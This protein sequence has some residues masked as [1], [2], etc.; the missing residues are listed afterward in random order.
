MRDLVGHQAE[1]AAPR[2]LVAAGGVEQQRI[3]NVA[4]QPP[5]LHRAFARAGHG[6]LVELGQRVGAA[7]VA[8]VK[9]QNLA[10]D[11]HRKPRLLALAR[12][13]QDA[14]RSAVHLALQNVKASDRH[15]QQIAWHR[16]RWRKAVDGG[17]AVSSRLF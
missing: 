4:D 11:F 7:K 13:S 14:Q 9:R 16:R 6:H 1:H 15:R 17:S 3:F 12:R 10:R 8:C 5:V 2:F